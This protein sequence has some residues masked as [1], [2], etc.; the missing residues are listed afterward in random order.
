M[1]AVIFQKH[2]YWNEVYP[3]MGITHLRQCMTME[4]NYGEKYPFTDYGQDLREMAELDKGMPVE[5]ITRSPYDTDPPKR[6]SEWI[7]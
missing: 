1:K 2:L 6:D 4:Y 5:I 3:A 7:N